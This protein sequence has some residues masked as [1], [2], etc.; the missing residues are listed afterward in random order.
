MT[1]ENGYVWLTYAWYG[2]NWW[3]R[4]PNVQTSYTPFNCSI[5]QREAFVK[6]SFSID[7]F[8]FVEEANHDDITELGVVSY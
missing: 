8:P 7:H 4:V 3:K 6:G 2:S 1:L 5:Q